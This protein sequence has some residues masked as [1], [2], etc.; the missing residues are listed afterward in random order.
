MKD[1]V[2][3]IHSEYFF[4]FYQDS[5]M[6]QIPSDKLR[7]KIITQVLE[8]LRWIYRFIGSNWIGLKTFLL[9]VLS[10]DLHIILL[11]I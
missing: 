8:N 3:L 5:L 2:E 7:N 1:V 6:Y 11:K 10:L 9:N 4:L